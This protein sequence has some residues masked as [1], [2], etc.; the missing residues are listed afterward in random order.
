MADYARTGENHENLWLTGDAPVT[1]EYAAY[2]TLVYV[3]NGSCEISCCNGDLYERHPNC[4]RAVLVVNK[5]EKLELVPKKADCLVMCLECSDYLLSQAVDIDAVSFMCNSLLSDSQTRYDELREIMDRLLDAVALE[6]RRALFLVRS[7]EYELLNSLVVNFAVQ[8]DSLGRD[9]ERARA[10]RLYIDANYFEPLSLAGVARHF[11]MDSAYLSKYFKKSLGVNFKDYLSNV[12]L[13]H[14]ERA[15]R[16]SDFPIARIA[17][18]N[19]FSN[20]SSF[21]TAFKRNYGTTPSEW[22]V[23]HR[24][25]E[26][27]AAQDASGRELLERFRT[28][29]ESKGPAGE[30]AELISVDL[31]EATDE[32]FEPYWAE[33]VNFGSVDGLLAENLRK[34][35]GLISPL[36][37]RHARIWGVLEQCPGCAWAEE[38]RDAWDWLDGSLDCL[39][40]QGISPWIDLTKSSPALTSPLCTGKAWSKTLLGFLEHVA[41]RYGVGKVSSWVFEMAFEGTGDEAHV[42]RYFKLFARARSAVRELSGK[43]ML[44]GACFKYETVYTGLAQ[45]MLAQLAEAGADFYSF[46]FYPYAATA[47]RARRATMRLTEPD[48][49]SQQVDFLSNVLKTVPVRPLYATEW[50]CSV[51]RRNLIND[52]LYKGAYVLKSV[53]EAYGML[54]ALANRSASDWMDA[55]THTDGLLTG[56]PGLIT[57]QDIPKPASVAYGMLNE[58]AGKRLVGRGPSF[59]AVEDADDGVSILACNY[60]HPNQLYYLKDE[61][62]IVPRDIASFFPHEDREFKLRVTGLE[63]GRY[64]VR[65]FTCSQYSASVFDA[66]ARMNYAN[67]LRPSDIDYLRKRLC[68]LEIVR[69]EVEANGGAVEL[70]RTAEPN[71][72]FLVNFVRKRR[73]L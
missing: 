50:N 40:S 62:S 59:V 14:A 10:I 7:I 41:N 51:S 52:T 55:T 57:R 42:E 38:R 60:V 36:G 54:D 48:W 2:A 63:P 45:R 35:V 73:L 58:V 15:L 27:Q 17:T 23:A 24:D 33:V 12:R 5:G 71:E 25:G 37:F 47:D 32:V 26:A 66:W 6:E 4:S 53:L 69:T 67:D 68:T 1:I 21:I 19:G 61:S 70:A 72:V 22:R 46:M 39:V 29:R 8:G 65:T 3:V 11:H 9:S 49:L 20:I 13:Y 31:A 64:E 56:S 43:I 28:E 16:E 30:K 44:G 18:E 34:Q